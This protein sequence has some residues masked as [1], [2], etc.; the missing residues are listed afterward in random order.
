VPSWLAHD[1]A[2]GIGPRIKQHPRVSATSGGRS[3]DDRGVRWNGP[4]W[5]PC[6][7]VVD[8]AAEVRDLPAGGAPGGDG[9]RSRR[10]MAGRSWRHR[11]HPEGR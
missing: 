5:T 10:P 6:Q 1:F 2:I 11:A 8:P 4:G 9:D 3:S 7:A